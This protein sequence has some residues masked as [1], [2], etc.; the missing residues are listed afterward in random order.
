MFELIVIACLA[1][2]PGNCERFRVPF[3]QPMGIMQCVREGQFQIVAWVQEHP[4][5]RMRRW[6]CEI[7]RA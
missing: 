3:Q 7:P 6:L 5:W 4:S 2:E 1:A